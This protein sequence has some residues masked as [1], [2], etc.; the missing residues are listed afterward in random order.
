MLKFLKLKWNRSRQLIY[1]EISFVKEKKNFVENWLELWLNIL[2][3]TNI[4]HTD[5]SLIY[6]IALHTLNLFLS[7]ID[8][9]CD[10]FRKQFE[11][12]VKF[13]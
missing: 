7:K 11:N 10:R 5:F 4:F 1:Y 9:I 13:I 3:T 8:G 2:T 6:I 12:A